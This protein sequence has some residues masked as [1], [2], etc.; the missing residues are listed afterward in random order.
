LSQNSALLLVATADPVQEEYLIT[1][2]IMQDNYEEY[3]SVFNCLA[4]F[5]NQILKTIPASDI[6]SY[7][8][9]DPSASTQFA[10]ATLDNTVRIYDIVIDRVVKDIHLTY[11]PTC[12]YFLNDR[13]TLIIGNNLG[14]CYGQAIHQGENPRID[15]IK[16]SN[17]NI[18]TVNG[19]MVRSIQC[20]DEHDDKNRKYLITTNDSR[21]RLFDSK[22]NLLRKF[23][24]HK[25]SK[26]P[27]KPSYYE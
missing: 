21:I 11:Q 22:F 23:K 26:L 7:I 16:C 15:H 8:A 4:E 25:N 6:V 9:F 10:V 24:G 27:M 17:S 1:V 18:S 19:C 13:K 20:L 2:W 12:I 5:N 14:M 3:K